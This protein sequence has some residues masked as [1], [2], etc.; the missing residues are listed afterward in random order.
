MLFD[1]RKYTTWVV[2]KSYNAF[3]SAS[4]F[5][6][7]IASPPPAALPG[8]NDR[9]D[10]LL[11]ITLSF[12]HLA[13]ISKVSGILHSSPTDSPYR[14]ALVLDF[15]AHVMNAAMNNGDEY[16]EGTALIACALLLNIL[17]IAFQAGAADLNS[18]IEGDPTHQHPLLS[19]Q[20][21]MLTNVNLT[22]HAFTMAR[23][24]HTLHRRHMRLLEELPDGNHLRQIGHAFRD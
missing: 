23:Q 22:L 4:D 18:G 1:I 24:M 6:K 13:M 9:R 10:F 2:Q 7:G 5:I 8:E 21:Q 3:E 11:D 20:N 14:N 19:E 16:R 15:S 17:N 12:G